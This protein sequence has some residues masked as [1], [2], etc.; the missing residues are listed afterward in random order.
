MALVFYNW[1]QGPAPS[2]QY[3]HLSP[4]LAGFESWVLQN[5]GG[6]D[7]GGYV[8]RPVVGGSAW[9][10]HAFGAAW[11]WAPPSREAALQL[12]DAI[13]ANP[14]AF[15]IQAI[16]DYAGSRV[17]RVGR[18]WQAQAPGSHGGEMG[19]NTH[20]HFEVA[21]SSWGNTFEVPSGFG[22]IPETMTRIETAQVLYMAG[23]RGDALWKMVAIAGRESGYRPAAHRT[24]Q[25]P[26]EM[27][28]D[29]GLFQINWIHDDRLIRA[30]IINSPQDLFNPVIAARAAYF[31][32]SGG[33]EAALGQ[34]WGAGPNGWNG[35]GNYLYGTNPQAA[36]A[37]VNEARESGVLTQT[38]SPGGSIP[39]FP[40]GPGQGVGPVELPRDA[41]LVRTE[42]GLF[43]VFNLGH[44]TFIWYT[45]PNDGSVEFDH[46]DVVKMSNAKFREKYPRGIDG[47]SAL[48]LGPITDEWGTYRS[49]WENVLIEVIG[50][51]NPARDDPG[52]RRVLAMYAGRPDMSEAELRNRLEATRWWNQRTEQELA[53]NDLSA[54]ERNKRMNDTAVQMA[55][56][57]FQ[58]TGQQAELS[59]FRSGQYLEK[60]AS[61]RMSIDMWAETIVKD[62]AENMPNS[63]WSR[64][65]RDEREA[66]RQRGVDI[67]N[68]QNQIRDTLNTWGLRWNDKTI[69]DWARKIMSKKASD[70]DLLQTVQD[71]A[72]V[73]YPWKDREIDTRTASQPWVQAYS[74]LMEK[75]GTLFTPQ[76]QKALQQGQSAW[77]FEQELKRS[78]EW[79]STQNGQRSIDE[80]I[81]EVGSMFGYV[82]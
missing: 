29:R 26:S 20:F 44:G 24:D 72:V 16:H 60:I 15:G 13:I 11:D 33:E 27:S 1:Q 28:G 18:G 69:E 22:E 3:N 51:R 35:Q 64:T 36:Q 58:L 77:D 5:I 55:Q 8:R 32:S 76:I 38:W 37:A 47:G 31:L 12:V 25:N 4:L 78:E 65:L 62:R 10:S 30:G 7:L 40:S 23:F 48:E 49:Y 34:L 42:K 61:G 68:T 70:D 39:S 82:Q 17:W 54:A 66:K 46:S 45:I 21:Q 52:V 59:Q 63:P 50:L 75:E 43:A 14:A 80:T 81:S 9:S 79:A 74:T 2:S 56:V 53:W 6:S 67:E 71:Q 19:V 41:Q 57:W 73:L